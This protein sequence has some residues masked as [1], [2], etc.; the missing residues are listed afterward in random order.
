MDLKNKIKNILYDKAQLSSLIKGKAIELSFSKV[1]IS[2]VT[3]LK[4]EKAFFKKWLNNDYNADMQYLKNNFDKRFNPQ[5]IVENAKSVIS[6]ALNYYPKHL[7]NK[8]LPIISKYT[9]GRDYH[10]VMKRM[11]KQLANY[12]NNELTNINYRIF[13]DSAPV[14]DKKWAELSGIGWVGKHSLL[15]NKEIGSFF[16]IGEIILDLELEY[17]KPIKNYCGTCTDCIDACPT[18]AIVSE[19]V[20]DANKCISYQTI[21]NKEE[22]NNDLKG[23]F[24]NRIFGCD[25]CQDV[26]P[27]NNK[28]ISTIISDFDVKPERLSLSLTDWENLTEDKFEKIFNGTALRRAGYSGLKR[29]AK[30]IKS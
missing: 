1:G 24:E 25:I 28:P 27:W 19:K 13:V 15:I 21:E 11:L 12:I 3:N 10:K 23:K 18:N 30:F 5:L 26:C 16:F 9:Y 4:Q 20:V 7:Q 17:D 8:D 22:I 29:N 14:L 2:K 6:V